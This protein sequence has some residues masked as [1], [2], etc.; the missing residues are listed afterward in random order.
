MAI[1]DS[2]DGRRRA[3]LFAR[4]AFGDQEQGWNNL[5]DLGHLLEDWARE[6][7]IQ[8]V[9]FDPQ[10][11]PENARERFAGI[12][13]T[14]LN[15]IPVGAED[16][17]FTAGAGDPQE[18]VRSINQAIRA[19]PTVDLP[20]EAVQWYGMAN[21]DVW[22]Q[23]FDEL[24]GIIDD[25]DPT[26]PRWRSFVGNE[27]QAREALDLALS[28]LSVTLHKGSFNRLREQIETIGERTGGLMIHTDGN[29]MMT[30]YARS[31]QAARE[32]FEVIERDR[33]SRIGR[34]V[35]ASTAV[36]VSEK[37]G[38]EAFI[39]AV[40]EEGAQ[41]IA[42]IDQALSNSGRLYGPAVK[43][44]LKGRDGATLV[45]KLTD[46]LA[47]W[48]NSGYDIDLRE[49]MVDHPL[50][51]TVFSD[52][53][54]LDDKDVVEKALR[55]LPSDKINAVVTAALRELSFAEHAI[56]PEVHRE[57]LA[58]AIAEDVVFS[59]GW[60]V[61]PN[62]LKEHQREL[63]HR[64]D[65]ERGTNSKKHVTE[66][67]EAAPPWDATI[68]ALRKMP[69]SGL[70]TISSEMQK[71]RGGTK[72]TLERWRGAMQARYTR[73]VADLLRKGKGERLRGAGQRKLVDLSSGLY[74][75]HHILQQSL[76]DH[77]RFSRDAFVHL[78][79]KNTTSKDANGAARKS[80]LAANE[81]AR[82]SLPGDKGVRDSYP[83]N[84]SAS[85]IVH[86]LDEEYVTRARSPHDANLRA[87]VLAALAGRLYAEDEKSSSIPSLALVASSRYQI[88]A[89]EEIPPPLKRGMARL[90]NL[91]GL[92]ESI[93]GVHRESGRIVQMQRLSG[94]VDPVLAVI[95]PAS[96]DRW[97]R[98]LALA[99]REAMLATGSQWIY[100]AAGKAFLEA[101][102]KDA[103]RGHGPT[104]GP[105]TNALLAGLDDFG[106]DD[107]DRK[108]ARAILVRLGITVP[109]T[110]D[111]GLVRRVL[112]IKALA[113]VARIALNSE[114]GPR[115]KE[116]GL[117]DLMRGMMEACLD[118]ETYSQ[119]LQQLRKAIGRGTK[120]G[121]RE[122]RDAID[123]A[124][125]ADIADAIRRSF[126]RGAI[127]ENHFGVRL[128]SSAWEKRLG[129]AISANDLADLHLFSQPIASHRFAGDMDRLMDKQQ[130]AEFLERYADVEPAR[131]AI[132]LEEER[133]RLLV[134][135]LSD[136]QHFLE[137]RFGSAAIDIAISR[138]PEIA[139][140]SLQM[141]QDQ[142]LLLDIGTIGVATIRRLEHA[143]GMED[144][145]KENHRS[146]TLRD[147]QLS[148]DR[149]AIVEQLWKAH[150][151][152]IPINLRCGPDARIW[153]SFY[154]A[155]H[156]QEVR[157]A[158]DIA[159]R[160]SRNPVRAAQL[161][162]GIGLGVFIAETQKIISAATEHVYSVR[163]E[164]ATI[165]KE[166]HQSLT[167]K[168]K[169]EEKTALS[170]RE[171]AARATARTAEE[172]AK[173]ADARRKEEEQDFALKEESTARSDRQ[174][175]LDEIGKQL[176]KAAKANVPVQAGITA[177]Q[178]P[179]S[180]PFDDSV[181]S[182]PSSRRSLLILKVEMPYVDYGRSGIGGYC[183]HANADWS[184]LV[185]RDRSGSDHLSVFSNHLFGGSPLAVGAGYQMVGEEG[186]WTPVRVPG[187]RSMALSPRVE[188]TVSH[189]TMSW[190]EQISRRIAVDG[191]EKKGGP[192]KIIDA[193]W[194]RQTQIQQKLPE[195]VPVRLSMSV[196]SVD[197]GMAVGY[198]QSTHTIAI[199]PMDNIG[200]V[201]IGDSVKVG[202]LPKGQQFEINERKI[203]PK[204]LSPRDPVNAVLEL[205]L[206]L[207]LSLEVGKRLD[208]PQELLISARPH[209]E[210]SNKPIVLFPIAKT[211]TEV[212]F[213]R[214]DE[215]HGK[216]WETF[217]IRWDGRAVDTYNDEPEPVSQAE[218]QECMERLMRWNHDPVHAIVSDSLL[219]KEENP[220]LRA[221]YDAGAIAVWLEH[222]KV[223][224]KGIETRVDT[225]PD[226]SH[227]DKDLLP[228]STLSDN[229]LRL[230]R[231]IKR[232]S[233]QWP[234]LVLRGNTTIGI[235]NAREESLKIPVG[236]KLIY[237]G[238]Q[239]DLV[240][241]A[242]RKEHAGRVDLMFNPFEEALFAGSQMPP[243]LRSGEEVKIELANEE[244]DS[245]RRTYRL[246]RYQ[247]TTAPGRARE[248]G[249]S[250]Q[251]AQ[252]R[253]PASA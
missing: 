201:S 217:A 104:V 143:V 239:N 191:Q 96:A 84:L 167:D 222:G 36:Y 78:S 228:P 77:E 63:S 34:E 106:P 238:S 17:R 120:H 116:A 124:E 2:R 237:L 125:G 218:I 39:N 163:F 176:E 250:R 245:E 115:L 207:A 32:L 127:N 126:E 86:L 212:V 196:V 141:R 185:W 130:E 220:A 161:S 14:T 57:E 138:D 51:S 221:A 48:P 137:K 43:T 234:E 13:R 173:A 15:D 182:G 178:T 38:R 35:Y 53:F 208:V 18:I 121:I 80:L 65:A 82:N 81:A 186:D 27:S 64:M 195:N 149:N 251:D 229:D 203:I 172:N 1:Y 44:A 164:Q 243:D 8:F 209:L 155:K 20:V 29:I 50:L 129:A 205:G 28:D 142:I 61:A 72:G 7:W 85:E 230:A 30:L 177:G 152:H 54:S 134:Q 68:K 103:A 146:A 159:R 47:I 227:G 145:S 175:R 93:Y 132:L 210:S 242:D 248:G 225:A 99:G 170:E 58:F 114:A 162:D 156:I 83:S 223:Q 100:D 181:L 224:F 88:D 11:Y 26:H 211:T 180:N 23:R 4:R 131:R 16:V 12:L 151:S 49:A 236:F 101:I 197:H 71:N 109:E 46:A 168:A 95:T 91:D 90:E 60:S 219:L 153:V 117:T 226:A 199:L 193:E 21:G 160:V 102:A 42:D 133:K 73:A 75:P 198:D 70:E 79:S 112:S 247:E 188:Q 55:L 107:T 244:D 253:Q 94:S 69:M 22:R 136:G 3:V 6:G 52:R 123:A 165:Q 33:L 189:E 41:F 87:C 174:R 122:L 190:A 179:F 206:D 235:R 187:V 31:P 249:D 150:T 144:V 67:F 66:T 232:Q 183:A 184:A 25:S 139:L 118:E 45:S 10:Q 192:A 74:D 214:P 40:R 98:A 5:R 246:V 154:D 157:E 252:T 108:A 37:L 97:S 56:S 19:L 110:L 213:A 135:E 105:A 148:R 233:V 194:I 147:S 169:K 111:S 202:L 62:F 216:R 200:H 241:L 89:F 204:T 215:K 59:D 231:G 113:G 240:L 119:R 24:P 76:G 166:E 92:V 140:R 158:R 9:P 171:A 128:F